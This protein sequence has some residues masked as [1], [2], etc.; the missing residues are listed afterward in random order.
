MAQRCGISVADAHDPELMALV[1]AELDREIEAQ[2][3]EAEQEQIAIA[4]RNHAAPPARALDGLGPQVMS[5]SPTLFLHYKVNERLDF[6]SKRDRE[7][8]M[9]RFPETRVR[10][11]ERTKLSVGYASTPAGLQRV[12]RGSVRERITYAGSDRGEGRGAKE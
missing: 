4:Q 6:G 8:L 7:W 9:K 1:C 12:E 3:L 2:A 11:N 5:L 10:G